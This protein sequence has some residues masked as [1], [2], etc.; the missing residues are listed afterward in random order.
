M[1]DGRIKLT[2]ISGGHNPADVLS[3]PMSVSEKN[4]KLQS[5]GIKIS[6]RKLRWSDSVDEEQ[7]DT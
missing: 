2:K 6:S 5:V 7:Y 3:K 4:G 1:R